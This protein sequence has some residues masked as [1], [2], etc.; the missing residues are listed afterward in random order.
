MR[1]LV[2]GPLEVMDDGG[3]LVQ[4][5][6]AK[7]RALLAHLIANADRVVPADDLIDEL[8]GENPP[9]TA[10]RTLR[11]YVSR[12]RRSLDPDRSAEGGTETLRSRGDG[13]E[14][15][16][17]GHLID[18]LRFEQLAGDAHRL[19]TTGQ[20]TEADR[21]LEEALGLW[22]G[23]A[24]EGYR[25]TGFGASEGERLDEL[26]RTATE[27]LIDSR[28]AAGD[29]GQLVAEL[30]AM[31]REE[32]LRE[33]RWSQLMIA[34]YRAGRQAEAL[35]AFL[36]AREVLVGELG[37]EPG[38]ELQRLHGAILAQDPELDGGQPVPAEPR[39]RAD[40]CPYKGLARFE[41]ADADF[42]FGREQVVAEAVAHLVGSR[43][44]AL[45]GPS[46]SGKSSL[47]RAGLL[48]ALGSGALPGSDRWAY[49]V[50]R[51]G[52]RPLDTFAQTMDEQRTAD[53][54]LLA[55]DQ[56]EEVFS[57]CP[58]DAE[59]AAFLDAITEAASA[60]DGTTA[61]V[62]AMRADF[63]GRCV[64]HRALA[65]L[66][67]SGQILVG[68]MDRDELRRA[69]EFPAQR[70]GL[71][72]EEQL[73]DSL[74]SD[75]VGQPGA[76][77]LLSTALL[78]LW[79]RRR[80]RT[81]RLDDYLRAGGVE[82]AVARLAEEAFGRLDSDGQAA[83]KRILLRLA[84]P[85]E[86]A[87]AVRRRAPLSEFDLDRD[88]DDLPRAERPDRRPPRHRLRRDGRGRP[89]GAAP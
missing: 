58:D 50:I 69:V 64:E 86:T 37:I 21:L 5:A 40:V 62:I 57:A 17:A 34:L 56:F 39:R 60:S 70:A 42:F 63:Y 7:E 41:T 13:Y 48:H 68:P 4:I 12:L 15:L 53:R 83:A 1:F 33:R 80:H 61:I 46:G 26:R 19:L 66:L 71:T 47:L 16:A 75:T 43:F 23:A 84:A 85:G 18:A 49:S 30:Q 10:A 88:A 79:T 27:D 24:F 2:L 78:E 87:Q 55:I 51:P 8:W 38:P 89:R 6:G 28:L 72:V 76:L 77:P 54:R 35:Q 59:R 74:V 81:L 31:V 82:G 9:R 25:Y 73:L 3:Q 11:S 44:L 32:P 36:R 22:R 20:P 14:L 65:S 67:A 29:A 52:D 45:V